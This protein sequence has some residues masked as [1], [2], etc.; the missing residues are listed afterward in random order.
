MK[1][2]LSLVKK[3]TLQIMRDP[4][5]ILIAFILPFIL[6]LI[7]AT[8]ISLDNNNIKTGLLIEGYTGEMND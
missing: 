2:M 8:A 6:I 4:S 1:I 3:E 5:S 7:F